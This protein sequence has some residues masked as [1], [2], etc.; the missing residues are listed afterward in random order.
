MG[1]HVVLR[2]IAWLCQLEPNLKIR[3]TPCVKKI[4]RFWQTLGIQEVK[5]HIILR[6][7]FGP[8]IR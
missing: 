1:Y 8:I 6:G 3:R 2:K 5:K 4:R 7:L